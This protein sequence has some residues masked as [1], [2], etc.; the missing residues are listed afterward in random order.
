MV[1]IVGMGVEVV[2]AVVVVAF[3]IVVECVWY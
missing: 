3:M 2:M 1:L